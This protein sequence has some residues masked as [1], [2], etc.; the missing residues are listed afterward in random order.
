MP[1]V[2]LN[3]LY[4]PQAR[5]R[6][7]VLGS[8]HVP[9]AAGAYQR[10]A[11]PALKAQ[12]GIAE[13]EG[14]IHQQEIA[15]RYD[16]TQ[17]ILRA[18]GGAMDAAGR[19]HD[20]MEAAREREEADRLRHLMNAGKLH[21][22]QHEEAIRNEKY[23]KTT[24]KDGQ[25]THAGPYRKALDVCGSFKE[26]D[27]YQAYE[28]LSEEGKRRFDDYWALETAGVLNRAAEWQS[29]AQQKHVLAGFADAAE[30]AAAEVASLQDIEDAQRKGEGG[31][32]A[33]T[34]KAV[35]AA[36]LGGK[37]IEGYID[38][39]GNPVKDA[40]GNAI[41]IP[42]EDVARYNKGRRDLFDKFNMER[43]QFCAAR[44]V[45]TGNPLY[46]NELKAW[47]GDESAMA[48]CILPPTEEVAFLSDSQRL[49][50]RKLATKA[51]EQ[52]EENETRRVEEEDKAAMDGAM[53]RMKDLEK[54]AGD[55]PIDA[56]EIGKL[57]E[58]AFHDRMNGYVLNDKIDNFMSDKTDADMV[59]QIVEGLGLQEAPAQGPFARLREAAKNIRD[60]KKRQD[61]LDTIDRVDAAQEFEVWS[62]RYQQAVENLEKL[63]GFNEGEIAAMQ[64]AIDAVVE[65]I[66]DMR[67][68][69]AKEMALKTVSGV[70]S[71]QA[72]Y[73]SQMAIDVLER[74]W[75]AGADG[76]NHYISDREA[77]DIYSRYIPYMTRK[78]KDDVHEAIGKVHVQLTR[79]DFGTL[80]GWLDTH[81]IDLAELYSWDEAKAGKDM[82]LNEELLANRE[83]GTI[84]G[85]MAE[86]PAEL[87]REI[88]G[89]VEQ[90]KRIQHIRQDG[91]T[92]WQ[93]LEEYFRRGDGLL[94]NWQQKKT[95][96]R[97]EETRRIFTVLE[98]A[99][100]YGPFDEQDYLPTP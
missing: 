51:E 67:T 45:E 77:L 61:A 50:V 52:R 95:V 21:L 26:S 71:Q 43:L 40:E 15:E 20:R 72:A 32:V 35:K 37:F 8:V 75:Y 18:V 24:D 44:Y 86:D 27:A 38:A 59:R 55:G 16:A 93:Y 6:R 73:Y 48:D 63:Q 66:G 90:Y 7:P 12:M 76:M 30:A 14:H 46:L 9:D 83:V 13:R 4:R 91:K 11:M 54:A 29:T 22:L 49:A 65:S 60:P 92:L 57:R 78:Q 81:G 1:A 53:L 33:A 23:D 74:G 31:W 69:A 64:S 10:A 5:E 41:Q 79:E 80:E 87:A 100:A 82:A 58:T 28:G 96:E 34:I 62:R 84:L 25:T 39:A 56:E 97:V 94:E 2:N 68:E 99:A 89:A 98:N 3:R 19:I 17:G 47:G 85:S 88:W 36:E 42:P 70:R